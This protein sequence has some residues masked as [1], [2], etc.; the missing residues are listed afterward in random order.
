MTTEPHRLSASKLTLA[1]SCLY[2]FRGDVRVP[3]DKP[4][5]AAKRGV[6]VH[7]AI[8]R[9]LTDGTLTAFLNGSDEETYF[10]SFLTWWDEKGAED[11]DP[12][13]EVAYRID[14]R[15]GTAR[16]VE[17]DRAKRG[18]PEAHEITVVVDLIQARDG[19]RFISDFKTGKHTD[20]ADQLATGALA[21]TLADGPGPVSARAVYVWP[22]SV[23]AE[24][25]T[26]YDAMDTDAQLAWLRASLRRL[27]MAEPMAGTHCKALYCPIRDTCSAHRAWLKDER[28][29]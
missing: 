10:A 29:A 15:V 4:G 14:V 22:G 11:E 18:R 8:E 23:M 2:P 13:S 20:T 5:P 19:R 25:W 21:V 28:A 7:A 26:H 16:R 6:A 12:Q 17:R 9:F 27:P 3:Y 24:D 1:R